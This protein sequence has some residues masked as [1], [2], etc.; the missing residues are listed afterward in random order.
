MKMG[1]HRETLAD[2]LKAADE[3]LLY[4]PAEIDWSLQDVISGLDEH[5][6]IFDR[7]D[8]LVAR[9]RHMAR[10]G[11][12]I[13]VMSNGGFGGIHEKLLTALEAEKRSA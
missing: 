7:I 9:V 12:H 10:P 3:V 2:S 13:L 5:A 1:V 8:S 11:D 4:Q 6:Q